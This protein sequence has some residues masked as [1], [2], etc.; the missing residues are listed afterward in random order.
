MMFARS[1]NHELKRGEQS[2]TSLGLTNCEEIDRVPCRLKRID[3]SAIRELSGGAEGKVGAVPFAFPPSLLLGFP[4][5]RRP[6][7]IHRNVE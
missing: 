4:D 3:A 1:V 2:F 5:G 7:E 6:R